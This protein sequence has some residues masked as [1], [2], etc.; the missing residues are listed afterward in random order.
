M[1]EEHEQFE[2]FIDSDR[3]FEYEVRNKALTQA[4]DIT[5]WALSWKLKVRE[6][7]AAALITKTVGSGIAITG[8]FNADP[9]QNTQRAVVTVTDDDTLN[10]QTGMRVCELKRM[11]SGAEVPIAFGPVRVRKGVH[12]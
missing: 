4:I 6:T 2:L 12:P 11:D 1:A 10:L 3:E 9:V 7:D 5:G 8:V